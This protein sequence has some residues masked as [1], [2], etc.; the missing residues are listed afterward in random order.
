MPATPAAGGDPATG[1]PIESAGKAL[2]SRCTVPGPGPGW[3]SPDLAAGTVRQRLAGL[4]SSTSEARGDTPT[5][6]V[7]RAAASRPAQLVSGEPGGGALVADLGSADIL[8]G[9]CGQR[10]VVDQVLVPAAHRR[11]PPA[12]RAL[13]E[14][15]R[16]QDPGPGIDMRPAC[17]EGSTLWS[18]QNAS[19]CARSLR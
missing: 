3:S 4:A 10:A 14:A 11:Q 2:H 8:G 15:Q 12:H 16:F 18:A 9:G 1:R 17:Y 13:V 5:T 6:S 7:V 19:Q